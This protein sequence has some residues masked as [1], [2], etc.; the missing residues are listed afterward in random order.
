MIDKYEII[1]ALELILYKA[2]PNQSP[3][4][5]YLQKCLFKLIKS[6]EDGNFDKEEE[7]KND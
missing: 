3:A 5:G 6:I 2:H 1:G 4:Q 7:V